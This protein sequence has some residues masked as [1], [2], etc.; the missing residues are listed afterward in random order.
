MDYE[1]HYQQQERGNYQQNDSQPQESGNYQQ[2][3]SQPQESGNYQQNDYQ[4]QESSTTYSQGGY[5][6]STKPDSNLIWAILCT[7]LCCIP[8]GIVSIVYASKVD[9]LW[10][11]GA[12]QE[13]YN[14]ANKAKKWA[15]WGAVIAVAADILLCI[16]YIAIF[17]L[18][19][20]AGDYNY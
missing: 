16:F 17:V 1:S 5:P 11:I 18:A 2:N 19:A 3:D 10:N 6:P 20:A 13:A 15:I 8:F 9:S 14:A 12:Y 7:I 4:P